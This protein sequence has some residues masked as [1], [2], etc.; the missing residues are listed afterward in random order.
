MA[1]NARDWGVGG[2]VCSGWDVRSV[3]ALGLPCVVPGVRPAGSSP[4]DQHV[5]VT[6]RMAA[7]AGADYIVV[8]RPITESADPARAAEELMLEAYGAVAG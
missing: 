6:P 4:N 1:V 5:V 3:K 2:I 8:G 7:F